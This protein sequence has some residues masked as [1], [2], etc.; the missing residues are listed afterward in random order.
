MSPQRPLVPAVE[1]RLKAATERPR[2][3][4]HLRAREHRSM[5]RGRLPSDELLS[6]G[7]HARQLVVRRPS[8][9]GLCSTVDPELC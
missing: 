4:F 2:Y 5:D 9:E 6:Q 7:G 1:R 3:R 8:V